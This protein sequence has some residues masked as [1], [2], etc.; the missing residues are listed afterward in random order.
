MKEII[1]YNSINYKVIGI[2]DN[3]NTLDK[4]VEQGD[5]SFVLKSIS[6]D[7]FEELKNSSDII[8]DDFISF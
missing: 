8:Y 4:L 2:E 3:E 1:K 5:L 7:K 6:E